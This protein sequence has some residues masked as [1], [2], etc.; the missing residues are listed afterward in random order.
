MVIAVD[1][2]SGTVWTQVPSGLPG[3][4]PSSSNAPVR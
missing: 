1:P 2:T 4:S 3:S